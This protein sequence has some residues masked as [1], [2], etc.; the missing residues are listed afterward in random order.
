MP[1]DLTMLRVLIASPGDCHEEREGLATFLTTWSMS[2]AD[3]NGY[4]LLP[5]MFE[6]GSTASYGRDGQ[7]EI[8]EQIVRTSDIC[9]AFLYRRLGQPT[10]RDR[11]GTVEE[12]KLCA[13]AGLKPAVHFRNFG[14]PQNEA[15]QDVIDYRT[16]LEQSNLFYP[17]RYSKPTDGIAKASAAVFK[18]AQEIMDQRAAGTT[19][20]PPIVGAEPVPQKE[21]E[22]KTV[23]RESITLSPGR[24][25]SIPQV[26]FELDESSRRSFEDSSNRIL[27]AVR[28]D[29]R[30]SEI[31][32]TIE[33]MLTTPHYQDQFRKVQ[34]A[35]YGDQGLAMKDW[36]FTLAEDES[37]WHL[38]NTGETARIVEQYVLSTEVPGVSQRHVEYSSDQEL[39]VEAGELVEFDTR[40]EEVGIHEAELDITYRVPGVTPLRAVLTIDDD[41][42]DGDGDP[43]ELVAV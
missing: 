11:S 36:S 25:A 23:R 33:K 13:E 19:E 15:E 35:L 1:S 3:S 28:N 24:L 31:N 4:Y 22:S 30:L 42:P 2:M 41:D 10:P 40:G 18:R 39:R 21:A 26:N 29:G 7:A 27:N 43:R 14:E 5:W 9:A 38:L 20:L 32:A 37:A 8:N 16:E 34:R 12:I 17:V 6:T